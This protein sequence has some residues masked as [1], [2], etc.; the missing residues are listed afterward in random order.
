V[1]SPSSPE[2][3]TQQSA[4]IVVEYSRWLSG[5]Q[6]ED[7]S[8]IASDKSDAD[9]GAGWQVVSSSGKK[10][11]VKNFQPTVYATPCRNSFS[12]FSSAKEN[13]TASQSVKSNDSSDETL[14]TCAVP[15][16]VQ[17]SSANKKENISSANFSCV[18]SPPPEVF[19]FFVYRYPT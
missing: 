15:R 7:F 2:G 4:D 5:Q 10:K 3:A 6:R 17:F 13:R 14:H 11:G 9:D 1:S 19:S 12:A 16:R 8:M 18:S